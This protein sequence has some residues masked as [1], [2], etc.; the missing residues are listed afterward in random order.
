MIGQVPHPR[1]DDLKLLANPL[2][3]DGERLSQ[4]P[5]NPPSV[6]QYISVDAPK[7]AA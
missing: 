2:K 5:R 6:G 7:Q 4:V 1:K 3:F